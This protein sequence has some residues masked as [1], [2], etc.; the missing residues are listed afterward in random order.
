ML[1]IPKRLFYKEKN[2]FKGIFI[3]AHTVLYN[4][5]YYYTI[6]RLKMPQDK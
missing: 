2:I 5:H 4:H 6:N 3:D 1:L